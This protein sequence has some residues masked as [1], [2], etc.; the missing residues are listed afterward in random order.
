MTDRRRATLEARVKATNLVHEWAN[1]I[2][3]ILKARFL[4]LVGQKILKADGSMMAK[5]AEL[6]NVSALQPDKMHRICRETRSS[7]S[8]AWCLD[9]CVSVEGFEGCIYE[10][11][12][13]YVGQIKGSTLESV[14]PAKLAS[15][16]HRTNYSADEVTALR[17]EYE[18]LNKIAKDAQSALLP[19]GEYDRL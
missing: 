18:R 15:E 16:T 5:Y 13:V 1:K 8:L 7:Y 14:Y 4:P 10:K 2:E 11:Q 9:V 3:P 19:F 6:A 12:M 17:A